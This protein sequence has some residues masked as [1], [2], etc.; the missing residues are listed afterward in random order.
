LPLDII[1][2]FCLHVNVGI[3]NRDKSVMD[4]ITPGRFYF[5]TD[6]LPEHDRFPVFC[7]EMFRHIV[8]ADIA[9]IGPEPFRGAL[10]LRRAGAV[11]IANISVTT[12][13]ISRHA[14]HVSDG[15]DDVVIQLWQRGLAG[16]TQGKHE[17]CV[18]SHEGL[19]ID[20][21][22]PAR[23]C[24]KG[25][26]RFWSLSIPRDRITASRSEVTRFA[27]TKLADELA[28][29]LLFGYLEE[30][31]AEG[32]EGHRTAQLFGDHLV[33]LAAL[34]LGGEPRRLAQEGGIRT[35]R[36][37]AILR[38]IERRSGDQ[39]LN[40]AV[41]AV[42]LGV[43]PRY[44]HLLLE[45]TGKSFTYHVLERRLEKAAA[46]LRD[47]LWR[48]RTRKIADIA[49][50]SGFTDL[51]YFNRAFRRRFGGTPSDIREAARE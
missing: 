44:V 24:T 50:E 19:I 39:S 35:A 13:S 6:A 12:A 18:K 5:D 21:A 2:L 9:K 8:G 20:N 3:C 51:S 23:V 36:R 49:A 10:D 40:A 29:R 43:T 25:P 11:G 22:I 33:E 15:D 1:V 32:L 46:L 38:E 16:M 41:I 4:S 30:T 42:S 37:S 48:T 27:G 45:E 17:H 14:N 26:S 28:L 47:P 34:A 7:E 31:I